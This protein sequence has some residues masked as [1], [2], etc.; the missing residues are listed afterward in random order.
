MALVVLLIIWGETSGEPDSDTT[1]TSVSRGDQVELSNGTSIIVST[2]TITPA[3]DGGFDSLAA[4]VRLC[5]GGTSVVDGEVV[6]G[7][8]Y[9]SPSRFSLERTTSG[10]SPT[11]PPG[12]QRVPE[13]TLGDG[14]CVDGTVAFDVPAGTPDVGI[15]V[16]YS[17]AYGD[18]V[19]WRNDIG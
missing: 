11:L 13:V 8:N 1:I 18:Q 10:P 17:N 19:V 5:G 14:E 9:V 12:A 7:R 16:V 2:V 4:D 3:T 15:G 6:E